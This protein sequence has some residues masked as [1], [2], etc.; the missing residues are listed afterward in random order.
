MG[1]YR[2]TVMGKDE[3]R[4]LETVS[5]SRAPEVLDALPRLLNKHS[6]CRAVEVASDGR[7]IFVVDARSDS[8]LPTAG[9]CPL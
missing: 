4:I 2:L 1:K 7:R 9:A 5:F 3:G 8:I 6:D